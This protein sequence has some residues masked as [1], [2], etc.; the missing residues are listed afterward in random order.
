M[1]KESSYDSQM[2]FRFFWTTGSL[3]FVDVTVVCS[4][5]CMMPPPPGWAWHLQPEQCWW[6]SFSWSFLLISFNCL[7]FRYSLLSYVICVC[8]CAWIISSV[9]RNSSSIRLRALWSTAPDS[10]S[11]RE[12]KRVHRNRIVTNLVHKNVR[13]GSAHSLLTDRS[14]VR[15]EFERSYEG[16]RR[17]KRTYIFKTNGRTDG[18][19]YSWTVSRR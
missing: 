1:P 13:Q 17:R 16:R 19:T 5:R 15:I 12:H 4:W 3:V 14:V 8:F 6:T 9:T 11:S 10:K 18:R 7:Y 2:A